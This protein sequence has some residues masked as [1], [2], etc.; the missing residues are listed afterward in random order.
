MPVYTD[1]LISN[2]PRVLPV[3][4]TFSVQAFFNTP[5]GVGVET[6]L[7]HT[8]SEGD[9]VTVL[10]SACEPPLP[11]W[12]RA[13][14][15]EEK[16]LVLE[17]LFADQ[18]KLEIDED[19][20]FASHTEMVGHISNRQLLYTL[21]AG[22]P[23]SFSATVR[24][25]VGRDGIKWSPIAGVCAYRPLFRNLSIRNEGLSQAQKE[26]LVK[27][28]PKKVFDIEDLTG[29]VVIANVD[30]CNGC[31]ACV[32]WADD[33][34]LQGQHDPSSHVDGVCTGPGREKRSKKW[35]L[36]GTCWDCGDE[37]EDTVQFPRERLFEWHRFTV[38]T[39][40]SLDAADAVQRA[41]YIIQS[42]L[43]DKAEAAGAQPKEY[44]E[45]K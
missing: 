15:C 22:E 30:D 42:R 9:L 2:D 38:E 3:H 45:L 12:L 13:I 25:G 41:L 10:D 34:K 14:K 1:D 33:N 11:K 40:G 28:C 19:I 36:P 32:R 39:S 35:R 26:Q 4:R 24:K 17:Y 20:N 43:V 44:P 5:L 18:G 16:R 8:F 21:K 27:V 23:L 7:R 6:D 29:D 31:V 37:L